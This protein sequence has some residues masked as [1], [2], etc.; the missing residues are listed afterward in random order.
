MRFKLNSLE[1]SLIQNLSPERTM[2][3]VLEA[4]SEVVSY[5]LA[6]VL[7]LE[8]EK[9]LR[10][11]KSKGPLN[12]P[13]LTDYKLSLDRHSDLAEIIDKGE[14][15]VFHDDV[16]KGELHMDTYEGVLDLPAG[17][18]CLVAPLH[19]EGNT[20]GV[21]TLDH[22]SCD[23]FTP[24]VVRITQALSR[25]IALAL[26]QSFSADTL[27][28]ER[29]ALALERDTLLKELNKTSE[30]LIGNSEAWMNVLEKIRLIAATDSPVMITGET[31]TG[32]EQVARAIH[33]WSSRAHR[34]FVALNCSA[35]SSGLAESEL[36]G[37]ERGAFTGAVSQRKGRFE[38]AN[39]GTLFLDEVGDLPLDIQPK[40]LRALQQQT[41]ER[42][43]GEKTISS[44][45]RIICATHVDLEKAV[46]ERRFREDLYYRLN[47]FPIHLPPLRER[48]SD[49][50]LLANHFLLALSVKFK[51]ENLVFSDEA[52]RYLL[53]NKWSGNVRELQN[54][55]ERA[56]ILSKNGLIEA[57]HLNDRVKK[58]KPYKQEINVEPRPQESLQDTIKQQ[59]ISALDKTNWKIY[60]E[61]G[62]A[63]LLGLKPTTL[64]SKMKKLE[65]KR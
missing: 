47:V 9:T 41:F 48:E 38:L 62:A 16:D 64:Q 39:T 28:K 49:I 30:N 21:L 40:L 7:S 22:R 25:L 8:A 50:L 36:F 46:K 31:G 17:H 20:L 12:T 14:V 55:L 13:R 33:S 2:E 29:D 63:K 32:K 43:G 35:L 61:D 52:V 65:I 59:I 45:V 37:H 10:V 27:L 58:A 56:A 11:R 18:S 54:V 42:L 26:A 5:E 19:V 4:L 6:V 51:K 3:I 44:D 57:H 15:F 34:P 1:T 53:E 24:Q 23:M 60:G